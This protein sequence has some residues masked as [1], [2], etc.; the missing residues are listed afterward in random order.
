MSRPRSPHA[1]GPRLWTAGFLLLAGACRDSAPPVVADLEVGPLVADAGALSVIVDSAPAWGTESR[2]TVGETPTLDLGDPDQPFLGVPPVLSLSD[3]RIVVADGSRQTIRYFDATGRLLATAGGRADDSGE[4]HGLGWIGRGPGD[5]LVAYDFVARRLGILDPAGKIARFAKLQPADPTPEAEP[6]T[7]FADG[8]VLFRLG[9][10]PN[11]FPG[12]PGTLLQDSASYFR[13]DLDGLPVA[14]LG[15]F[16]QQQLFGV[17]VRPGANPAPFPVPFGLSTAAT[18]RS[19]SMLIGT[20][21][22][23]EI[24]SVGPDGTPVTLLRASIPREAI[25]PAETEAFTAAAITRLRTNAFEMSMTLD[26]GFIQAIERA[27]FPAYK[28]AFGRLLVDRTGALWVSG[29]INPPDEPT[30]W[31]VFAATGEWL[32][33]VATPA[34]LRIDEIGADYLLGVWKQVHGKERVRRYPLSR[35]GA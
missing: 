10:A 11:P 6:M 14:A 9:G 29:P 1:I 12:A 16:P 26:S 3:G 20:G 5:S 33:S 8:T 24:L 34:G 22:S 27:P 28:P 4:F 19:D 23:F 17:Q 15:T 13:F 35:G 2:W 18:V 32:G 30:R 25:T 31:N 21:A 7:T